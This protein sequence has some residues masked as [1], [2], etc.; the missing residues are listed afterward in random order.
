VVAKTQLFP[1]TRR[2]LGVSRE[3]SLDVLFLVG[4]AVQNTGA[5]LKHIFK[6][7]L[8]MRHFFEQAS[9]IGVDS[10]GISLILTL[11]S[12]M[13]IALQVSQ[14]LTRQGAGELVGALVATAILRELAPIMTGFA[15]IAMVGSAYSAEL[16]TMKIQ[17]QVDALQVLH[18]DPLRYLVAPRF[19]AAFCM[20]P[21]MTILTAMAGIVG[22]MVV[23]YWIGGL[24]YNSY[25]ESVWRQIEPGDVGGA[26][27]KAGVFGMIIVIL[28][29]TIGL[30][31]SGGAK[32][33]GAS[34]T[35]AVVWSFIAM[36][37]ADYVLSF[38]LFSGGQ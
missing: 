7:R 23:S 13:V 36:A 16:A 14:E 32:E 34:T 21:L 24:N 6:R 10:L 22:G 27:L 18:V 19:A 29:T 20:L 26:M 2:F 9:F 3:F 11:F 35:K 12:G 1:Y 4:L 30:S 37:I 31:T 33:V 25:M 8:S 5:T 15:V 38:L 28:S 17:K